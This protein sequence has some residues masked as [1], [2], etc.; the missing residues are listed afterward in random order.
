MT[1]TQMD[2]QTKTE[3]YQKMVT[4]RRELHAH[5]ELAF[6]E[7]RTSDRVAAFLEAQGIAVHRGLAG[8]GVAALLPWVARY[9]PMY[10][11]PRA[12]H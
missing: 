2:K 11:Q 4:Y 8:T 10:L 7:Q 6:Q 5:P 12:G 9:L 3:L 1:A